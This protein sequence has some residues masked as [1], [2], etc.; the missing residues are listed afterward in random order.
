MTQAEIKAMMDKMQDD[1]TEEGEATVKPVRFPPIALAPN[2]PP[3]K[4]S[5]AH[6]D[7]VTMNFYVQLGQVRLKV[8]ELLNLEVDSVMELDKAAGESADVFINGKAF[9]RGEILVIND[10]FA[11]RI[12]HIS[13]GC[14]LQDIKPNSTG[15]E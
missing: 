8:R 6:L 14:N 7:D 10:K 3:I 15:T 4:A 9:A 2:E 13:R 5:L 1:E 12:N 11:V